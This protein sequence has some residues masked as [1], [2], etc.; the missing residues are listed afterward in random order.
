MISYV[1]NSLKTFVEN[2]SDVAPARIQFTK[3][4]YKQVFSALNFSSTQQAA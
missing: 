2:Y 1:F 4:V 3:I